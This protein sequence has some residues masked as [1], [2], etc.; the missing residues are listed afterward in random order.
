MLNFCNANYIVD[1]ITVISE[2]NFMF[3]YCWFYLMFLL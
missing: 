1:V 3:Y 2:T